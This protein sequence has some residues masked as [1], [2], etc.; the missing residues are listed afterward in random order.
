MSFPCSL[1]N[2]EESRCPTFSKHR[3]TYAEVGRNLESG[4]TV[5]TVRLSPVVLSGV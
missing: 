5:N 3:V 2:G 4:S 1:A